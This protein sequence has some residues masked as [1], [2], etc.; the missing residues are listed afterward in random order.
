MPEEKYCNFCGK[1]EH[2]VASMFSAG[3]SHIC[4]DCICYCYEMLYGSSMPQSMVKKKKAKS[5][6]DA[7]QIQLKRPS[8]MKKILD[9]IK[10]LK[11]I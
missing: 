11:D 10:K 9:A 6:K 8:E 2:E 3:N 4:D 7:P 1:A 5:K